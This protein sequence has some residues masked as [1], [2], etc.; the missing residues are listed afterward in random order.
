MATLYQLDHDLEAIRRICN[1]EDHDAESMMQG[2]SAVEAEREQKLLA[3]GKVAT[4]MEATATAIRE[5]EKRL[6]ARRQMLQRKAERLKATATLSMTKHGPH[7]LED[8]EM[9]MTLR[10]NPPHV[11]VTDLA[12]VHRD[13]LRVPDPEVNKKA[14]LEDLKAGKDVPGIVLIPGDMR[15]QIR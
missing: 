10:K 9:S 3:Y 2:L 8:D 12:K 6:A 15:V 1:D 14:A 11:V 13:Y 5:H 7:T 4:E